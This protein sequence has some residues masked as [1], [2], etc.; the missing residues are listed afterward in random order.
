MISFPTM[1]TSFKVY[2]IKDTSSVFASLGI[3][4]VKEPSVSVVVAAVPPFTLIVAPANGP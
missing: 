4:N 3:V 1:G 2:P